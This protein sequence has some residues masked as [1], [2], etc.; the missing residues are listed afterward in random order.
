M[1][2]T[3]NNQLDSLSKSINTLP[4]LFKSFTSQKSTTKIKETIVKKKAVVLMNKES[5]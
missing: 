5:V 4:R 2:N 1:V 3:F